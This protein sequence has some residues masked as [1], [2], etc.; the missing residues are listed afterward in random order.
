V[1]ITV[2]FGQFRRAPVHFFVD[3]VSRN[4]PVNRSQ[5]IKIDIGNKMIQSISITDCYRLITAIDKNRTHRKNSLS[6]AIDWQLSIKI[7]NPCL[8]EYQ[9]LLIEKLD[10][11]HPN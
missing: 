1:V 4:K 8:Q 11:N 6:I 7:D 5:S 3:I 10:N 9:L 2:V